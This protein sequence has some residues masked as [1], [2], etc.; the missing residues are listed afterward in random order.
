MTAYDSAHPVSGKAVPW[1]CV[2]PPRRFAPE[3]LEARSYDARVDVFSFGVTLWQVLTGRTPFVDADSYR[4]VRARVLSGV[5]P[6]VSLIVDRAELGDSDAK[7]SVSGSVIGSKDDGG[8]RQMSGSA[9][10]AGLAA[11]CWSKESD[12]RPTMADVSKVVGSVCA[13]AERKRQQQEE[14]RQLCSVCLDARRCMA[15][16][17]CGHVACCE[18][19]ASD[20]KGH[21]CVICFAPSTSAVK[22]Y[23]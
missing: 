18:T 5:R 13:A 3:L 19:C 8:T 2:E 22:I 9:A 6:D 21:P 10:L 12:E 16:V 15:F 1:L 20:L 17:P 14:D 4:A 11:R 23:L 7:A